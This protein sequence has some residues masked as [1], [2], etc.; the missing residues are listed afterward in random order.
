[1]N[2]LAKK[3]EIES[4][5]VAFQDFTQTIE[6]FQQTYEVLQKKIDTLNKKLESK[7]IELEK[8]Y[9]E[10]EYIKNFLNNV[11]ENIYTGVVVID[12][13]GV[14][15]HFNRAA[16]MIT[17]YN[18]DELIGKGYSVLSPPDNSDSRSA[19]YTLSSKKESYHRQKIIL[20][21]DNQEKSVEFSIT[22]L[23]DH[24]N[25]ILGAVETFNDI[26]EIKIMQEKILQIET[27]AALG[28][29]SASVA[30]EI[31]NPLAGITGFAGLL[32]RQ[33]DEND[34][35][36]NLVRSIIQ[37]VTKLNDIISNL[38]T[39]TRP[40]K[41]NFTQINLSH[42][43]Y[44][45][46]NYF[47]ESIPLNNKQVSFEIEIDNSETLIYLDIQLFQQVIMNILKNA[48]DSIHKS[49]KILISTKTNLFKPISDIL[50]QD[51]KD[52][53]IRLFSDV[54]IS[55]SDS[56]KGISNEILYKIF[57]PFFTTKDEGNGLGLAICKKIIQLHKGDIHVNS[58][59]NKGSSF[60][61]NLP[62]FLHP[63]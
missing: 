48:C 17:G 14:I 24:E 16:E 43:L 31:R 62:L 39:L 4:L 10:G 41:L 32:D 37:G 42:F 20:T 50:E 12:L 54:E 40:Q 11:L 21:A 19:L 45:I 2:K 8:K 25:Q 29:M 47:K 63:K 9:A 35:R 44:D 28:E 33:I 59:L 5:T 36:K 57:N 13:K 30:H 58:T 1:M 6:K 15:T 34:S 22:L 49:G 3:Q 23:K 38:L 51:E 27:L 7:N 26:S 46:T 53:L 52:E 55:I 18:K 56:G 61:I 60:I